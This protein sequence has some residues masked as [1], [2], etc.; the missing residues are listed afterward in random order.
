MS[1]KK[2]HLAKGL[3]YA[4]TFLLIAIGFH[5]QPNAGITNELAQFGFPISIWI[6][7]FA[8]SGV[9]VGLQGVMNWRWN[10]IVFAPILMYVGALFALRFIHLSN[11]PI[12]TVAVHLALGFLVIL[13][14][15]SDGLSHNG[16]RN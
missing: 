11:A 14:I 3:I 2:E 8:L 12:S 10:A 4:I 1:H 16:K 9:A 15:Y 13:D 6:V 5:V 7:M